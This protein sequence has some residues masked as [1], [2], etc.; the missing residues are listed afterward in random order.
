MALSAKSIRPNSRLWTTAFQSAPAFVVLAM[1]AALI[2]LSQ[3]SGQAKGTSLNHQRPQRSA[4]S[5]TPLSAVTYYVVDSEDHARSLEQLIQEE[6][7]DPSHS[8][9]VLVAATP[10]QEQSVRRIAEDIRWM[11]FEGL[12][13]TNLVDLRLNQ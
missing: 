6:A 1:A 10:D 13:N 11:Q 12:T 5:T 2:S 9:Q 7:G 4:I 8:A 3:D